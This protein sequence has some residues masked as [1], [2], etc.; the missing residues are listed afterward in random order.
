MEENRV[1]I[2]LKQIWPTVYR[3]INSTLYFLITLIKSTVSL[4][5]KQ[6]KDL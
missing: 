6:I 2:F 3:I 1:K 5:I 4:A